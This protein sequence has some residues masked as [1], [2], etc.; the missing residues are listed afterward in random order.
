MH[1]PWLN[2]YK[3][4]R[5]LYIINQPFSVMDQIIPHLEAVAQMHYEKRCY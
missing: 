4:T 2:L 5:K 1:Q 3:K